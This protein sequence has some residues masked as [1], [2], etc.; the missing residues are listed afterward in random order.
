M[1]HLEATVDVPV[2]PEEAYA[3]ATETGD[4]RA[5][6]DPAIELSRWVRGA[7]GPAD[8]AV[9]FTR[10]PA[11]RRFLLRYEHVIPGRQLAS[12]MI[13]GP[14]TFASYGEGMRFTALPGGGTRVTATEVFRMRLP[15]L[16][17]QAGRLL[18]ATRRRALEARMTAF[19]AACAERA[20]HRGGEAGTGA[21]DRSDA[22]S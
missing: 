20:A 8:G 21:Q 5:A 19:A 13:K 17:D 14:S 2:S 11:G 12:R 9:L 16:A 4:E 1:P 6:W 15:A 3:V 7:A 18:R 22:R 10:S